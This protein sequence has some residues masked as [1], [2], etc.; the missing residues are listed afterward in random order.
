MIPPEIWSNHGA[1]KETLEIAADNEA[2][3]PGS[4][5]LTGADGVTARW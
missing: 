4:L 3:S 1:Q 2:P 5:A